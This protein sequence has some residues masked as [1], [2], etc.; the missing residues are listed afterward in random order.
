EL[1]TTIVRG[2]CPRLRWFKLLACLR[3]SVHT[4]VIVSKG[5]LAPISFQRV[6]MLYGI[7]RPRLH[8]CSIASQ[9]RRSPN[10][11]SN[12]KLIFRGLLW[13]ALLLVPRPARE[14]LRLPRRDCA[15]PRENHQ[16][17][18]IDRRARAF[19][20]NRSIDNR[21]QSHDT[22]RSPLENDIR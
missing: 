10:R 17:P 16:I 19:S 14:H 18:P 12:T 22:R 5:M 11:I 20:P 15:Q 13:R 8:D 7:L 3:K 4:A 9:A 1:G 21:L 6:Q 2:R